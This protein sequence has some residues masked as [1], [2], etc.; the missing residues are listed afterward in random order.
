MAEVL[1][2][3]KSCQDNQKVALDAIAKWS[4]HSCKQGDEV[5]KK[6]DGLEASQHAMRRQIEDLS[7]RCDQ[8]QKATNESS[9]K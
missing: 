4:A 7:A 9:K 6:M 3:M 2:V 8:L 5:S 1:S